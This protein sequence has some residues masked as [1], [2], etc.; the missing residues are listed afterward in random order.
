MS[1]YIAIKGGL[2][3]DGSGIDTVSE[4]V[5]LINEGVIFDVG[6]AQ[7]VEIP[8]DAK[9]IDAKGKTV[10]PGLMDLHVHIFQ[11]IGPLN[12]LERFMIPNSLSLLYAVKH[13]RQL[14]EAGFTTCRDLVY[15][16]PDY[17][18]RDAVSLRTALERNIIQGCRLEVAGV[19]TSTASH[20]DVIRPITLRDVH[21]TADGIDEV[22]K[23]TRKCVSEQVDWIKT[24]T[25]GGMA[26]GLTNDPNYKNYTIDELEV[27]VEEAH[28]FGLRVASHTEGVN[29]CLNAAEAGIDTIEHAS[30]LNDEII[31]IILEKG[32]YT[33]PTL[34]PSYYRSEVLGLP[35]QYLHKKLGGKPFDKRHLESQKLAIENGV[36]M[37]MGTDCGHVFP[38]GSN[39][40]ELEL[41][42]TKLGLTPEQSLT[43]ATR[44]AADALGKLDRLGTLEKRKIADLIIVNGNPLENIK[45]LQDLQRIE[46]VMKEGIIEVDKRGS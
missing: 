26:G 31:E 9:I 44:N 3:W 13:V 17:I 18:G 35:T 43:L 10:L 1:E 2:L 21:I 7:E 37:A 11:M 22:R 46:I 19:V 32:L 29:G 25:T 42:V 24:C 5:V 40:W 4:S 20:L 16:F 41:Y 14:L 23:M 33:I 45:V 12:Y 28:S 38:P 39:A 30:E 15:P 34:A 36:N 27:I 8:K 6:N